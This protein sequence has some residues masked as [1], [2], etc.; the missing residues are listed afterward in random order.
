MSGLAL[1]SAACGDDT[2]SG[3]EGSV[4]FTTWGE[5]YIEQE[6][7]ADTFEDG[8][9]ITYDKFLVLIGNIVIA[10]DAGA[11]AAR[12]DGFFLINH[13]EP[14]TKE[15]I[16]FDGLEAKPYTLVSYETSPAA[17]ANIEPVG[18][19]TQADVDFM[20]SEGFH[21]YIEGTIS[22]GTDSKTFKWGFGVPTLLDECE[23]EI[24]GKLT[25]G[26]LVTNGGDDVVELTIHGD[27]FF[28]DDLQ[29][30]DAVVRGDAVFNADADGDG[31]VTRQELAAVSL[32]DLPP[33]QYGTGGVDAVNDLD[34]FIE[35]LS[36]T[37]GHYRGEGEC[38][39]T[40]P[41]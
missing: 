30:P 9:S 24:D 14:G 39:L 21:V 26:V 25:E 11:E 13:T 19:A 4:T 40:D 16:T 18:A 7:P 8:Y 31:E 37:I 6:I 3:G 41:E 12:H 2:S 36:R 28:Y 32:I 29:S 22:N 5:E 17:A 35:F 1:L 34:A 33:D 23:G 38:F 10:D 20:A 27:H 15:L